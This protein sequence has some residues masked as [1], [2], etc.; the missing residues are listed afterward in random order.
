MEAAPA[1]AIAPK[2]GARYPQHRFLMLR[3][4]LCNSLVDSFE[5]TRAGSVYALARDATLLSYQ[6][7]HAVRKNGCQR[8]VR[9]SPTRGCDHTSNWAQAHTGIDPMDVGR[10]LTRTFLRFLGF[11]VVGDSNDVPS[12]S[13]LPLTSAVKFTKSSSPIRSGSKRSITCMASSNL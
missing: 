10:E 8:C 12:S 9:A 1:R 6:R 2:R 4:L 11:R 5:N 7:K 13:L 3:L